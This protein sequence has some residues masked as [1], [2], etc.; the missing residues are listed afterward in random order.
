MP[1]G[2]WTPAAPPT[3]P[4]LYINF[5]SDA[6]AA[7]SVGVRGRVAMIVRG[8][9]GTANQVQII[10]NFSE[11]INYYTA[12]ETSPDNAYY[13]GRQAFIGGARELRMYR[14][15]GT[16]A[17]KSTINLLDTAG[18]PAQAI[19]FDAKNEGVLG[20]TFLIQTRPNP[21]DTT[22]TDILFTVGATL[23]AVWTSSTNRGV[24]GHMKDL[25]NLVNQDTSNHWITAILV[26]E[27]NSTPATAS[28]QMAS[29]SNGSAPT[30]Q[31]Y[32]DL[33]LTIALEADEWDV[34]TCDIKNSDLPG[35]EATLTSWMRDLRNDGY[36]V[37][38]IMGS[39]L[40]ESATTAETT[41]SGINA[42]YVQYLYPG[43][44]QVDSQGNLLTK[45]GAAFAAQAAGIRA[46]LPLGQ[47]MTFYP[48]Q[49]V[50]SLETKFKGSTT[51]LLIN[52]GVTVL[53]KAGLHY[54]VVK[55][56]TTLVVPGRASD[57]NYIPQGF[58]KVSIVNTC[59]AI[60]AAIEL[61]AR[62][63]YIG[64]VPNDTAGQQAIVG[65]VRDFLRVMAGQRAIRNNYTVEV[66]ELR[67]SVG[68][69]LYL[70]ISMTVVDTIDVILVTVKV[71]A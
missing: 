33:L 35:I 17:A 30:M 12:S 36:R 56:V 62:T 27:G 40:A 67:E 26:T 15:M 44:M 6:L 63:N 66:S 37:T 25:V 29:G 32:V 3:R 57:G 5:I 69:R 47:G 39:G 1:G 9:W 71:G 24:S 16:G 18:T 41:A 8:S 13:A 58:K 22:K 46:S 19:R 28:L 11:L 52:N 23:V 21:G 53:A 70:D 68:E 2:P 65:V 60:A 59:D 38:M 50:I 55:G 45:R 7:I 20:N 14:I 54:H 42:E 48:L 4:G 49:E 10:D 51:D 61:A 31:N 64:K 43:A 34:F